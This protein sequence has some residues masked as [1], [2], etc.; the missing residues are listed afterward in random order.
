MEN[1]E[2]LLDELYELTQIEGERQLTK[3]E[4]DRYIEI[5]NYCHKN[6]I[7]IPFGIAI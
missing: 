6:D 5:V 2:K 1:E 4:I 3:D 7:E